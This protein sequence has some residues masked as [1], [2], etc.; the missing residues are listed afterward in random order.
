MPRY[1]RFGLRLNITSGDAGH[2]SLGTF[3]PMFPD[4]AY[5]GKIG[6][7]GPSNSIDVTP[8][9]TIAL[10][11]RIFFIPDVAFFWRQKTTDG[12]YGVVSPYLV[13][14]GSFSSSR[15]VG[16]QISLPMQINLTPHLTYT[17]A[18]SNL[19][20]GAFVHDISGKATTFLTNFMTYKF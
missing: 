8:N 4:N 2:G 13:T 16:T 12:I 15:F 19:M 3:N 10:T 1:T 18:F 20:G 7:V 5:S 6:L 9:L 14:P 17:V 11:R